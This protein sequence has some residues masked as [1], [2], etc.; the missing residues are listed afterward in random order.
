[1]GEAV[2]VKMKRCSVCGVEKRRLIRHFRRRFR[3]RGDRM[4]YEWNSWCRPCESRKTMERRVRNGTEKTPQ[5]AAAR[6]EYH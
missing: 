3:V 2:V 4:W 6:R 1:M 5:S